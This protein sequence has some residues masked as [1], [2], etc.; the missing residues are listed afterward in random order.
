IVRNA[1]I[2]VINDSTVTDLSKGLPKSAY[3]TSLKR[4]PNSESNHVLADCS[5]TKKVWSPCQCRL[6]ICVGWY[7]CGLKYCKGKG[8]S[9]D[10]AMSYRC[11]IKT[12]RK[13]HLF[14][15]YVPQKQTCLWDE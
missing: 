2:D 11:G 12:C 5:S 6:E 14:S 3:T 7:P 4:F 15:Y 10:S 13:C 8:E 1:R 9:K